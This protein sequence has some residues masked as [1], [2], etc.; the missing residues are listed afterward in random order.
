MIGFFVRKPPVYLDY[1]AS[2]PLLA[3]AREAV[4][5]AMDIDG[6][7]S[8]V[9]RNGRALRA[10]IQKARADVAALVNA[11]PDH[12]VFTAGATEAA[13]T[14]LTPHYTMGRAALTMG[15]LYVCA[16]DHPC[17]LAGGQFER[18]AISQ[19]G[20]D[21]DG[22]V[23]LG[24]LD[25]VL[26]GHDKATGLPLVVVH[27][28]NNETGV[29]QPVKA[30]SAVVKRHG[31]VLVVD[32][33]QAAGR[34]PVDLADGTIDYLILSAHKIGGPKGAG[35]IVAA[36]DLMMPLPLVGGGGQ[37]R[38]HRGGTEAA[39][40]IA[41]FGAAAAQA[42]DSVEAFGQ[43]ATLR[44]TLEQGLRAVCAEV[45]IHG[46]AVERLAN[47]VFFS[48]PGKKA[49]TMQIAFDL[50][51]FAV[52]SGSACSSGKVGQSHVLKAM[53]IIGDEGAV[54]VS[55]GLAT[56]DADIEAFLAAFEAQMKR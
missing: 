37:E 29:I 26:A 5:A 27:L 2:A 50:A 11:K 1:N 25:E 40:A 38:G 14:L 39:P 47:T 30:I 56:Q 45:V 15:H 31:G 17:T 13:A 19:F 43:L 55:F 53:G 12:V 18:G 8:S 51:G 24:A 36:S 32:A 49:E 9:H 20:V 48:V 3:A 33:V 46:Q 16:A 21:A 34:V 4:I 44:D 23:D 52:S 28:A 22:V 41:G 54:R 7:A 42:R 6:N 35:A 10:I